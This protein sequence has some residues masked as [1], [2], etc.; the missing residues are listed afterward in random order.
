MIFFVVSVFFTFLICYLNGYKD[1]T[2]LLLPLYSN[3]NFFYNYGKKNS[4]LILSIIGEI[5]GA[6]TLGKIVLNKI[7]FG[8]IDIVNLN[9]FKIYISFSLI[10]LITF[11]IYL[12]SS[13]FPFPISISH[14]IIGGLIGTA[15][16][17]N[18]NINWNN[19]IHAVF[20]WSITP[21]S[22]LLAGLIVYKIIAAIS[23]SSNNSYKKIKLFSIFLLFF[24][25]L[26]PLLIVFKLS[27]FYFYPLLIFYLILFITYLFKLVNISINEK[28][29]ME[30]KSHIKEEYILDDYNKID[31]LFSDLNYFILPNLFFS[32]GAN[33]VANSIALSSFIFFMVFKG[34]LNGIEF[35]NMDYIYLFLFIGSLI[36]SSGL[37]FQG[38]KNAKKISQNIFQI[39]STRIFSSN[40]SL[41]ISNIL[42]SYMG[43][44]V[45]SIY[46]LT[47]SY[48]GVGYAKGFQ[49]FNSKLIFELIISWIVTF[50]I[51]I[52]FSYLAC[53]LLINFRI[54]I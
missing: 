43:Y 21:L 52:I 41:S 12:I 29:I 25:Y 47:G 51:S 40:L 31:L 11:T 48:I 19:L 2:Y 39:D 36:L 23:F 17:F 5:I 9:P 35:K 49:I 15:F 10:L 18:L 33:D 45:S 34:N 3:K 27:L 4:F 14:T 8:F 20:I 30:E 13:F 44:R 53:M 37:L 54:I 28:K 42:F 1:G 38:S 26:F 6:L 32:H 24:I 7:L 22:G 16:A 50:G 46:T